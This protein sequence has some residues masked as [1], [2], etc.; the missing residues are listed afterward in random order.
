[1]SVGLEC[2]DANG[3]RTFNSSDYLGKVLGIRY[4]I[5]SPGVQSVTLPTGIGMS[6]LFWICVPEVNHA[7][8]GTTFVRVV[9]NILEFQVPDGH[10]IYGV[11]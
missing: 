1:M 6:Q 7:P 3:N 11:L 9:G 4:I 5:G 2:F 8:A 10:F